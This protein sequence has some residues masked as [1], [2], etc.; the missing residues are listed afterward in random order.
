M[1]KLSFSLAVLALVFSYSACTKEGVSDFEEAANMSLKGYEKLASDAKGDGCAFSWNAITASDFAKGKTPPF[2]NWEK[3]VGGVDGVYIY[4]TP[5]KETQLGNADHPINVMVKE[6]GKGGNYLQNL[7]DTNK[8]AFGNGNDPVWIWFDESR[9]DVNSEGKNSQGLND[10]SELTV[11]VRYRASNNVAFVF[12]VF[13]AAKWCTKNGPISLDFRF[14]KYY[15]DVLYKDLGEIT[16]VRINDVKTPP[17]YITVEICIVDQFGKPIMNE[18]KEIDSCFELTE[19]EGC[20]VLSGQNMLLEKL[21]YADLAALEAQLGLQPNQTID[22]W[23]IAETGIRFD[24]GEVCENITLK[25]VINTWI[26]ACVYIGGKEIDCDKFEEIGVC[27]E[28][29]MDLSEYSAPDCYKIVGWLMNGKAFNPE[30]DFPVVSCI[31]VTFEAVLAEKDGYQVVGYCGKDGALVWH[32]SNDTQ[33]GNTL[34]TCFTVAPTYAGTVDENDKT[35]RIAFHFGGS[36]SAGKLEGDVATHVIQPDNSDGAGTST[37]SATATLTNGDK[38]S[39][40]IRYQ[41]N[42]NK[43]DFEE[44]SVEILPCK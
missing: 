32:D 23:V 37:F 17:K 5:A 9:L 19:E 41:G 12:N 13:R 20:P 31:D 30:K 4:R 1:K 6:E 44:F 40:K 22:H 2:N 16:Q 42:G 14:T 10:D 34:K 7:Y 35:Y 36:G 43:S 15:Q 27:P 33:N 11:L 38:I 28:V 24:F 26:K 29:D 3:Q 25:P 21:G 39:F 8:Q 18:G